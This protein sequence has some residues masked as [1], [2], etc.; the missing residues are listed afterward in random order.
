MVPGK[1]IPGRMVPEKWYPRK[2]SPKKWSL[3]R[4]VPG[5]MVPVWH[6]NSLLVRDRTKFILKTS[7]IFFCAIII[8]KSY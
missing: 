6:V 7:R 1:I 8:S 3:G 5:K 4:M 2:N